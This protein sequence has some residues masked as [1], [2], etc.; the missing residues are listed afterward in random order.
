MSNMEMKK[1]IAFIWELFIVKM[2][3]FIFYT[4]LDRHIIAVITQNLTL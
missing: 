3:G 1:Q 2:G 4:A